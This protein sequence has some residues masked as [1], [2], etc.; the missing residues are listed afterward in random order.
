MAYAPRVVSKLLIQFRKRQR[1]DNLCVVLRNL[2][3]A[4]RDKLYRQ[5]RKLGDLDTGYH[6]IVL[7]NGLEEYDRDIKAV[8]GHKLPNNETNIYILVDSP[9]NK[10]NDAQRN[11]L[12]RLSIQF[13]LD[14]KQVEV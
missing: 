5:A 12:N 13:G 4:D 3:H 8:A 2:N 9:N 10:L 6:I 14:I 11:T 7:D 1:T